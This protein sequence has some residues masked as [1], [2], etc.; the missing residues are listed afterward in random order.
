VNGIRSASG[1]LTEGATLTLRMVPSQDT[2]MGCQPRV[3]VAGA[4]A[5]VP[6]V[7]GTVPIP[8]LR[9]AI[10]GLVSG[11]GLP[12]SAAVRGGVPDNGR[13]MDGRPAAERKSHRLE[14]SRKRAQSRPMRDRAV[15][16]RLASTEP[17]PL[18]VSHAGVAFA[19][20]HLARNG[21]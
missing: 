8:S 7:S 15:V 19:T 17:R 20:V 18:T 14:P 10:S 21:Q 1:Q 11:T 4:A 5:M 6:I 16:L 13:F 9:H 3:G 12:G 2:G